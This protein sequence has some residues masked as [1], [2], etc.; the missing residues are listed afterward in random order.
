M[1][2]LRSSENVADTN[3][4]HGQRVTDRERGRERE[5]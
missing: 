4:Y 3:F 2:A 1:A 5:E